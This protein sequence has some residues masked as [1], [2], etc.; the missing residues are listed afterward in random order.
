MM[1]RYFL[2]FCVI[3][4][5]LSAG[6]AFAL[7]LIEDVQ[8]RGGIGGRPGIAYATLTNNSA[9]TIH[10]TK[11]KSAAFGRIEIHTQERDGAI[12]RMRRTNTIAL[13]PRLPVK[14]QTGGAH[15]MLFN[16]NKKKGDDVILTFFFDSTKAQS[17][18]VKLLKK[19]HSH[20]KGHAP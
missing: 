6:N 16:E 15:L 17:V 9:K 10:L 20:D 19:P 13:P 2:L 8:I 1:R 18:R 7:V 4:F 12:V 11:V 14:L 5:S 3:G